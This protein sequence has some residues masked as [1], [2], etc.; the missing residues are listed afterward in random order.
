MIIPSE[1]N[2]LYGLTETTNHLTFQQ[3]GLVN[4]VPNPL[5]YAVTYV[6]NPGYQD[7]LEDPQEIM[8]GECEYYTNKDSEMILRSE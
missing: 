6:K 4:K 5:D 1:E 3:Q 2:I 8:P 7:F